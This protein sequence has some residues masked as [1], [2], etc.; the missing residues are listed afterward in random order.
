MCSA[1]PNANSF[2]GSCWKILMK[3]GA[4][5]PFAACHMQCSS[6]TRSRLLPLQHRLV[7]NLD[8]QLLSLQ[9]LP[10]I[11]CFFVSMPLFKSL[12]IKQMLE[13]L[14]RTKLVLLQQCPK[15]NVYSRGK[16]YTMQLLFRCGR[17]FVQFFDRRQPSVYSLVL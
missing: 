1:S 2:D 3:F 5:T 6:T 13:H 14:S 4:S 9:T 10:L 16:M 15:L 11:Q 17:T 12:C 7:V 8:A